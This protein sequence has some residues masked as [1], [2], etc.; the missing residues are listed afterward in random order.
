MKKRLF[1]QFHYMELGGAERALLGL[2]NA[3]DTEQ[4]DVDLFICQHTGPFMSL[5]PSK[6]H[7]LPE[8]EGYNAIER[9]LKDIAIEGQ[10]KILYARLKAKFKYA[11]YLRRSGVK[12]DGSA[13]H[14]VMDEVIPYLKPLYHL[15]EY[16]LAIS[17]LDPPHIVQKKVLAKKRIEWIHTDYGTIEF[18]YKKIYRWWASND[19]IASISNDITKTF[20]QAFPGLDNKIVLIENIISPENVRSQATR[21]KAEEMEENDKYKLLSIGRISYQK[22]FECIP[23]IC[24]NIIQKGLTNFKWYILGPGNHEVIDE[25]IARNH[26]KDYIVFLGEKENPYPFINACDIYVQPSRYEGKSITVREAQIL[27]KPV[28]ITPYA[29]ASSQIIDHVDGV[30]AKSMHPADIAES[31]NLLLHDNQLMLKLKNY[32]KTHDYGNEEEVN[33]LYKLLEV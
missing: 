11:C 20:L 7:L 32:L 31:I 33:K 4:I 27:Y 13:T 15:G 6:I 18:D 5:I 16:D 29:T 28:V 10:W 1:I 9:P 25:C 14:Y 24:T 22:N 19:Y 17:F 8:L 12:H 21:I 30:I 3:L 2:L 26:L 23:D